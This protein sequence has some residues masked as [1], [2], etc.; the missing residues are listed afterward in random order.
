VYHIIT[1]LIDIQT[2]YY[3]CPIEEVAVGTFK[4]TQITSQGHEIS[5]IHINFAKN[6]GEAV[7]RRGKHDFF[8][9][10]TEN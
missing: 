9:Q 4:E 8:N 7:K 2:E 6:S 10:A 3:R 5:K 1:G